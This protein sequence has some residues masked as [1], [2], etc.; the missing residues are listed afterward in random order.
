M[1]LAAQ[2][3]PLEGWIDAAA[4]AQVPFVIVGDWNRRVDVHG[5]G[6][7][8]WG[9]IDDADPPGLDLWRLPFNHD[10]SCNSGLA[11][12]IDFL[13]FDNRAWRSVDEPSFEEIVY[14]AGAPA[15]A[16]R[17]LPDRGRPRLAVDWDHQGRGGG[18]R[19]RGGPGGTGV[20]DAELIQQDRP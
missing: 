5:Q 4:A 7:H 14:D 9:E 1:T 10:S 17:P 6:D 16:L 11:K 3:G 8:L 12:P 15:H 13:V 19:L 20:A 2:R 18:G